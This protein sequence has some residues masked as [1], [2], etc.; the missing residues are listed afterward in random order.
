MNTRIPICRC[1][2]KT[3]KILEVFKSISE[4]NRKGYNTSTFN[5]ARRKGI[6]YLGYKWRKLTKEEIDS[7]IK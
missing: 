5:N 1:D 3:G 4:L 7:L 2:L 6:N